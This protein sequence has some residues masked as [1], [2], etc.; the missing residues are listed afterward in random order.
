LSKNNIISLEDRYKFNIENKYIVRLHEH[1]LLRLIT[2][3]TEP[4][5]SK[6][7]KRIFFYSLLN[8]PVYQ[9]LFF[10]HYTQK[11]AGKHGP[12]L[13]NK[14]KEGD[15]VKI[16][17][18]H[19]KNEIIQIVS[20][21]K[22]S[23]PPISKKALTEVKYLLNKFV[24]EDCISYFLERCKDFNSSFNESKVY[25]HEWSHNLSSYYE[26]IVHDPKNHKIHMLI[27]TYE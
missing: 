26:Y 7:T 16:S 10:D 8:N 1:G 4:K 15:F 19:I 2:L 11:S 3:N 23:C 14:L 12:F 21:P 13:I 27:M 18:Q 5:F 9:E 22:W 25:E 6:V 20:S 24:S 17:K